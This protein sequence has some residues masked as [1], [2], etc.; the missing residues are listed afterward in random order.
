MGALD[1]ESIVGLHDS[2]HGPYGD[3]EHKGAPNDNDSLIDGSKAVP[4]VLG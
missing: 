2:T 1:D 3:K 4:K